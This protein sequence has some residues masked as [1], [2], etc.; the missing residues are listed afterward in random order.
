[1]NS[2]HIDIGLTFMELVSAINAGSVDSKHRDPVCAEF[3]ANLRAACDDEATITNKRLRRQY[4]DVVESL[5]A[6]AFGA[7]Y[8]AARNS[9]LKEH[10][11]TP[12][13]PLE[14]SES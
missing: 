5:A 14:I 10:G 8:A 4:L 6:T 9:T 1:M 13:T 2:K 11:E 3:A 7:G 12:D